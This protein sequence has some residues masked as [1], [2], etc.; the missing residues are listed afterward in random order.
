M[1][2]TKKRPDGGF[3]FIPASLLIATWWVYKRRFIEFKDVRV[4]LACQELLATRC[5][6]KP[7]RV[8]AFRLEELETF[9][10][11]KRV[12]SSVARLER[13]GLVAWSE[14]RI[15][16]PKGAQG[17]TLGDTAALMAAVQSVENHRR[18]V[19]VPRRLLT[20]LARATRPAIVATALGHLLRCMYYRD[21]GCSPIGRCKASWIAE[22]FEMDLRN[23][24]SARKELQALG[25]EGGLL[26]RHDSPHWTVNRFGPRVE[27]NLNWSPPGFVKRRKSPPRDT[28]ICTESPP[29]DSNRE[30]SSKEETK[31]AASP[32]RSGFF[33]TKRGRAVDLRDVQRQNLC[34]DRALLTLYEQAT[35]RAIL[36][37]SESTRLQFFAAAE[38]ARRCG[39]SNPPGLFVAVIRRRL[40]HHITQAEEDAARVRLRRYAFAD[41]VP[42][43]TPERPSHPPVP[44]PGHAEHLRIRR[45]VERSLQT[46]AAA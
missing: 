21:E 22:H 46:A 44:P 40:W 31:N 7:G 33:E 15:V 34:D 11:L 42:P 3:V 9:S 43:A 19:P 27:I 32:V 4:W 1:P 23:I 13:A 2:S 12:G 39:Q 37:R 35:S 38:H 24:K 18:K 30:L 14:A 45:A 29:P 6:L 20:F 36:P 17:L 41:P 28:A 5:S 26:I 16:F 25:E 10:R 8:P